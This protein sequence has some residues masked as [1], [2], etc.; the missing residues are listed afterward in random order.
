MSAFVVG[1]VDSSEGDEQ[2]ALLSLV[3]LMKILG[4]GRYG[5]IAVLLLFVKPVLR[6]HGDPGR[7]DLVYQMVQ[8]LP[9]SD[10]GQRV[11][12]GDEVKRLVGFGEFQRGSR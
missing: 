1:R 11:V 3:P 6:A 8:F 4:L 7:G 12:V 10:R 2:N 9:V 5:E